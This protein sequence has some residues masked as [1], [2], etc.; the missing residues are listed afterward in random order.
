VT[1]DDGFADNVTMA[2]PVLARLSVPATLFVVVDAVGRRAFDFALP[3]P[4]AGVRWSP[5]A[6]WDELKAWTAAGLAVGLHGW[7]HTPFT[8]LPSATLREHLERGKRTLEDRLGVPVEDVAYPYGD[9]THFDARVTALAA[10]AGFRRGYTAVAGAN[11]A[12]TSRMALH[13]IRMTEWD[14][15]RFVARKADGRFDF[16]GAYQAA[17]HRVRR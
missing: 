2:L 5:P 4:P 9:L 1:F 12:G 15:A 7:T 8:A 10:E 17:R 13:R 6:T 3:A 11:V 16:Y 14:D